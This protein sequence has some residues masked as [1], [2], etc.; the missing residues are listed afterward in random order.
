ML[1]FSATY[2]DQ[3]QLAMAQVYFQNGHKDTPAVFDYYFRK[4][5]F[6]NG[7]AIFS[8]LQDLLEILEDLKFSESDLSYL[9]SKGFPDDF[10]GYLKNFRFRGTV[11]SAKEGDVVFPVRPIL[12]VEATMIEAQLIETL[13]LNLLNFQTLIATK[14]SRIK[15]VAGNRNLFEFGLRRAQG[16]GGYYASRAAIVGGFDGTSNVMAGKDFDVLASG[17]MAHSFIQ[18]YDDELT[19]FRAFAKG[20]PNDCVLLVDSYDTLKSGLPNAITVGKEMENAGLKLSG[21]RLDSGDLAYLAKQSRKMLDAAGLDYVKIVASNQLDEFVIKSLLEQQ[22]P[23]DIFGVGTSLVTGSP[24]GALD[25]VYKLSSSGGEPR[26][27]ISEN[28]GKVTIPHK[29]QVYR[30]MNDNG[31]LIGADAISLRDETNLDWMHDPK[32]SLK[33]LEVGNFKKEA[34]LHKFMVNG[35][36][37]EPMQSLTEI[38]E[39]SR[40]RLASLPAEYKRFFNPHIYK[41]GISS[42]LKQEREN[43]LFKYRK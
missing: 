20:R 14:A 30:L 29:K 15:L 39:Y 3:Y 31:E 13:L 12:Q 37:T 25:G 35:K 34:L 22:A 21:I 4:L 5:P 23:I 33:S 27:K 1:N 40:E 10:L 18:S 24:D 17:T 41:V 9:K 16:P 43:L 11:F 6:N 26:I 38:A 32:Q 2:T 8:G 28:F 42:K 7:Y 19:A 36:R